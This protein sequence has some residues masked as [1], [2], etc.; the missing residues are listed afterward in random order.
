MF[1]KI[2]IVQANYVMNMSNLFIYSH[3]SHYKNETF[4]ISIN[5]LFIIDSWVKCLKGQRIEKIEQ[6][7]WFSKIQIEEYFRSKQKT[8]FTFLS[9]IRLSW[10]FPCDRTKFGQK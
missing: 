9:V 10:L 5:A 3:Q 2:I 6:N 7:K 4:A 1:V 8:T